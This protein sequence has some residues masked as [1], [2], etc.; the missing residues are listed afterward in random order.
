MKKKKNINNKG[1]SLIELLICLVISGF[2]ILAAY[3]FVMVGTKSYDINSKTTTL[4]Q[5]VSYTNNLVA[6]TIRA[7]VQENAAIVSFM[8]AP[9]MSV[10]EDYK[11]FHTNESDDTSKVLGYDIAAGKLYIYTEA[12]SRDRVSGTFTPNEENLITEYATDF[13]AEFFFTEDLT[14]DEQESIKEASRIDNYLVTP[15]THTIRAYS[16]LVKITI[17]FNYNGKTDTSEVIYQIRNKS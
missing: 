8:S 5:E 11:E 10:T 1:F 2:V 13:E 17:T 7:A 16:N 15:V 6:E 12:Q 4:Q 3:S 14:D 9:G